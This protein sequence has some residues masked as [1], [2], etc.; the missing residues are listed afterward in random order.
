MLTNIREALSRTYNLGFGVVDNV[1]GFEVVGI[2][3]NFGVVGI[4]K[5]IAVVGK[6][7]GRGYCEG[8]YE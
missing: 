8:Y 2:V 3:R 7:V 6:V 1:R 5:G 4:V